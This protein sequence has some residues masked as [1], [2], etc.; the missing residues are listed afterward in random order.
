[1]ASFSIPLSGLNAD[2]T[3]LNTIAND[4]S[5]MNTTGFKSQTTNFADLFYQQVGSTGSGDPIQVGSGVQVATNS[6]DFTQGSISSTTTASDVAINGSGF[7]VLNGGSGSNL[8]TRA[9][10]FSLASSGNLVTS[11]GLNVMGYPAVNGVVNPNGAMTAIN[12]PESQVQAP[13]ATGTF[14]I[15]AT[16][17][18]SA[19]VGTTVPAQV[20][21]YDSLGQSYEAT[22]N[23]TKTGTNAWSYSVSLPDTLTA[24]AA[25]PAAATILPVTAAAATATPITI[26]AGASAGAAAPTIVP[27][28][29]SSTTVGLNTIYSYNFGTGGSGTPVDPTTN[30]TIGGTPLVIGAN[31]AV[32][33]LPAQVTAL[34]I[35]GVSASVTGNVMT[36]TVP[37]GTVMSGSMAS[38]LP[39]ITSNYTFN[40]GGTVDPATNLTI[41]GQ[42]A[43]G[44]AATIIAPTVTAGES[45]TQYAN[46]LTTALTTA[47]ITNVTVTPKLATNQLSIVGSNVT[48]AGGVSQDLAGTT[49]NYDFGSAATVDPGTN[50]TITGETATGATTTTS[51]PPVIA[52]ESVTAYAQA[53]TAQLA[54]KGITGVTVQA[55]GGQLSIVG[56][57]STLAG[58][59]S[60]DL[61][62][63]TTSFNFGTSGS[64]VAA[65]D[66]G[67][68]LTITGLTTSGASATI[69][70]PVISTLTPQPVSLATYAA[71]LTA[72]LTTAGITGVQVS[73]TAGGQ[74]SI[75]GANVTTAGS[76]IQDPVGS[77][78]ATGS[79]TFDSSGNLVSPAAN[80]A[81]ITF[82]GLSDGASAMNM[83]WDILGATGSPT[84]SQVVNSSTAS[85]AS[86]S[87]ISGTT[88]NGYASGQYQS[89]AV[90]S[91]G[92]VTATFSNGQKLNVGQLALANVAN[93]QGL[94][95]LGNGDYETT[96]ASGTASLGE[97]GSAGL[98]SLEGSALEGSNVNISQEFSNLIVAQR[99]FEANSKA[100]T[101]F[102]TIT[103]E[104]IN[105][106]H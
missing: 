50:L 38:D 96:L 49:T 75:V 78:N 39:G 31:E 101:T 35:P 48:T 15:T 72:A 54:A 53:L 29:P 11:N 41:S 89:F 23:F 34:N 103:Q 87:T 97:S 82:T 102:D 80:V 106:I 56:A 65:V 77:A 100:V 16:L 70:A 74:L 62:A 52:G 8:Y 83:T 76:L 42:T 85:S 64:N 55:T 57:N 59:M 2:S 71:S 63:T 3:S 18:S 90:G 43:T 68:N 46:D 32:N 4:L 93:D 58:N 92:T 95:M 61:T 47:G 33:A 37:T 66:P 99:A 105:M 91:D 104:T 60:Q 30:L 27:L 21:V 7:F 45:M 26:A 86:A 14:G 24:A 10:D 98:G 67:T 1:M 73:S 40:T 9:G 22:V 20:Q 25:T 6:T 69:A 84:I 44:A 19:A 13:Q 51:A 94:Q 81:G 28:T 88:Q 5:N 36:L 79:M 12:I 17:S